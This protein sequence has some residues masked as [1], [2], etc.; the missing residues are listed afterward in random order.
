MGKC[1]DE[2]ASQSSGVSS[3]GDKRLALVGDALL[4]VVILERCYSYRATNLVVFIHLS[5]RVLWCE[6]IGESQKACRAV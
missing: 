2:G 3:G 1:K 6:G 5:I 4:R